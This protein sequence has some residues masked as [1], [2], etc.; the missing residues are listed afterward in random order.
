M[1]V[2][3]GRCPKCGEIYRF[4]HD[5]VSC[6]HCHCPLDN[7]KREQAKTDERDIAQTD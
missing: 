6:T 2:M 7:K 1:N 5:T 4:Q 3:K